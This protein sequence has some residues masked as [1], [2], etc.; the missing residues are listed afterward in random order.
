MTATARILDADFAPPARRRL[1]PFTPLELRSRRPREYLVK[2]FLDRGTM[3]CL[4]A[5][6]G[7]GKTF[8]AMDIAYHVAQGWPWRGRRIRKGPVFYIACEGGGGTGDRLAA[9]DLHHQTT[10]PEC[11]YVLPIAV[12]LLEEQTDVG[13]IIDEVSRIEPA[14]ELIVVDTLSRALAGGNESSPDD[15]GAF[16]RNCDRI[17]AETGA[18]LMIVHHAGKDVAKGMRGHSSLRAATDTEIELTIEPQSRLVTA[19]VKKQRELPTEGEFHQTLIVVE[20]GR[21]DEGDPITSC[22]LVPVE[23]SVRPRVKLSPKQQ[24]AM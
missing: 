16:V 20:V 2:G 3:S 23:G 5:E 14:V 1:Q 8:F 6:S 24:R 11:L 12:N 19:A 4:Y 22:V 17:R 15:M 9:L 18:H 21:D 7:A 10:A 13:E